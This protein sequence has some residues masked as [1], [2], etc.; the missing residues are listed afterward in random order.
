MTAYQ[1]SIYDLGVKAHREG[2][3]DVNPFGC[4]SLLEMCSWSAGYFDSFR[5]MV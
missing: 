2:R 4:G 5:G 3:E 1:Q